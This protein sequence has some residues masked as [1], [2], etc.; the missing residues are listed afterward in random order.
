MDKVSSQAMGMG[1][2]LAIGE[3][4][5]ATY[6]SDGKKTMYGRYGKTLI[7]SPATTF[8]RLLSKT[9]DYINLLENGRG[10]SAWAKAHE[11]GRGTGVYLSKLL[12]SVLSS[13]VMLVNPVPQRLSPAD[14]TEVFLGH[15]VMSHEIYSPANVSGEE[16]ASVDNE[17]NEE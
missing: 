8:P 7:T 3:H 17:E 6:D 13:D 15:A 12:A 14:Q 11:G 1:A 2:V 16:D 10:N 4:A 9:R 5:Q